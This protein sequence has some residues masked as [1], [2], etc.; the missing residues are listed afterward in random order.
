MFLDIF[1]VALI[2]TSMIVGYRIGLVS[3]LIKM[4]GWIVSLVGGFFLY[5]VLFALFKNKLPVHSML[6]SHIKAVADNGLKIDEFTAL[7]PKLLQSGLTKLSSSATEIWATG[8]ANLLLNII[9]LIIVT[10]L[11]KF[12]LHLV[13]KIAAGSEDD[14]VIGFIDS[15]FGMIFGFIKGY[16]VVCLIL[17]LLFPVIAL[18]NPKL[19]KPVED[20]LASSYI[21]GELYNNNLAMVI[22]KNFANDTK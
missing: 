8:V 16:I 20:Q 11:I 4:I 9:C 21:T 10:F 17:A 14:N 15:L 6:V 19:S 2:L 18:T 1:V 13:S 12:L 3:S 7:F 22:F 5:P